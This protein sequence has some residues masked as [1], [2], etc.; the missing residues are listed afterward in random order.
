ME[1]KHVEMPNV[2]K[3][4]NQNIPCKCCSIPSW[5]SLLACIFSMS[6]SSRL[7]L[8]LNN[9]PLMPDTRTRLKSPSIAPWGTPAPSAPIGQEAG[10]PH[11]SLP[12][13]TPPICTHHSLYARD[14]WK[15]GRISH[16]FWGWCW[17]RSNII[18]GE[19]RICRLV[20]PQEFQ[21]VGRFRR[22]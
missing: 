21:S 1:T 11:P 9:I 19:G 22:N 12:A 17:I 10:S 5:F 13:P 7:L 8:P 20:L 6:S 16:G 15:Y 14:T 4:K 18:R 3:H 2:N